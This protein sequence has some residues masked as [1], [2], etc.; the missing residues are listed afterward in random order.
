MCSSLINCLSFT[1][2]ILSRHSAG[3]CDFGASTTS[4]KLW[5]YPHA[6][7]WRSMC[8]SLTSL[9]FKLIIVTSLK[10]FYFVKLMRTTSRTR[11]NCLWDESIDANHP[12][13]YCMKWTE[14]GFPCYRFQRVLL[15]LF[16]KKCAWDE[17]LDCK[18][19]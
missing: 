15:E 18:I 13:F 8:S 9:S 10:S 3:M 17:D 4:S 16:W 2:P 12:W 11:H 6:L 1:I 7:E 5:A 19:R 14:N